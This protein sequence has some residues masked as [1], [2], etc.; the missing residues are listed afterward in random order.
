MAHSYRITLERLGGEEPPV[1]DD[2]LVFEVT[3]HDDLL[4]VIS[5]MRKKDV[6]PESEVAEF[7][8]GLKLV[9]EVLMRHRSQSPFKE[10]FSHV[11]AFM[12]TLKK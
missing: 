4:R 6:L 11:G 5:L 10:L 1:A 12:R 9:A 7:T 3:N 8:I 2:A